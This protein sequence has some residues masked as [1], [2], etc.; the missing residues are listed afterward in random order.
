MVA[1][2]F[3][4]WMILVGIVIVWL[5]PIFVII[6]SGKTTASEKFAWVLAVVFISWF[7]WIFYL[8]LAPIKKRE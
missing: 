5:L 7:A 1:S 4:V 8:L 2:E 3:D 6:T